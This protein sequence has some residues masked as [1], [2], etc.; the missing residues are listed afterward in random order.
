MTHAPPTAVRGGRPGGNP[1]RTPAARIADV[2]ETLRAQRHLWLATAKDGR[3]HLVPLAYVWDGAELVCV[4]KQTTRSAR[5]LAE[6]GLV[7][8]AIGTAQ[9]VILIEAD[10]T[11]GDPDEAGP[12]LAAAL[13]SLPLNPT[14][15]PGVVLL[16]LRPRTISTW[17]DLSEMA[18]RVIMHNGVWLGA[19]ND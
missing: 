13:E 19:T 8:V 4:T 7:K 12:E 9:D 15:V 5:N 17:R 1:P 16:R 11:V 10:A 18:D 2:Q 14:R 3:P 6:S